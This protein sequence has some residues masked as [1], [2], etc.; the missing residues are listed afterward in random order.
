MDK[1]RIDEALELIWLLVED[2][3]TGVNRFKLSSED[4]DVE[5]LIATL[6]SEGLAVISG[7]KIQF[8]DK[9]YLIA[10]ALIRRLRLA[11]RLFTD[12]FEMPGD[13]VIT[14]ACKMEHILSEEL[15]HSA[16]TFLGHPPTCPHG[17]PIPRGVCCKKY[18]VEV[19]PL[20]TRL[21]EFEVGS[22]GRITFIVPTKSSRLSKLNSLGIT[23]GSVIRLLQKKPSYVIQTS[24]TTI[25]IAPEIVKEIY[26]KK[27]I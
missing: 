11:E 2:G 8:T 1:E 18:K 9:G 22:E 25:A 19:E 12:V 15:T 6:Q 14:D 10:K 3:H 4:N 7:D 20:V 5:T 26:V 17:K 21:S 24:E 13:T 23:A 27:V 16:C